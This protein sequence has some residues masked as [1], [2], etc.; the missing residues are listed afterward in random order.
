MN[1][2]TVK[3]IDL[4]GK[5]VIMRVDFN[6]PLDGT[7]ITDDTRVR[8]AM[9]TIQHLLDSGASLILM[10]H[11][12]RPSGTGY[13]AKFSLKP[14]ADH[15]GSLLG[16]PIQFAGDCIGADVQAQAAALQPGDVLLL[17]N[18]RFHLA[19][20][21]KAKTDGMGDEDAA[22]AKA[23]I[24]TAQQSMAQELAGLA[25]VYVNDAFGAAHRAH[26]STSVIADY[27]DTA[28]AGLLIEKE[29]NYLGK[30]L[31]GAESPFVAIIGGAKVSGK[32]E[33]LKTLVNKVDTLIIGGGMAYTFKKSRGETIGNS[34]CEDDLLDTARQI[35][36]DAAANGVKLLLPVDTVIA[37][38][39]SESANTQI[40][41]GNIPDDWEGLDVGPESVKLFAEAVAEAKTI[42]WNGPL[43]KFEWAPFAKGTM[44]ICQAVA[45]ADAV[46]IIGG[47]DSVSAVN[48][49]GLQDQMSHISTGG[50]ASLEFLEGKTLPGV[51]ALNDK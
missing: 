12:G 16:H 14:V 1:K 50:G 20:Q 42:I 9:P 31:N 8:A 25:D 32:L 7:T 40:V 47:G 45:D 51:A 2:K 28:V 49:S 19:E 48:S 30:A 38:D 5:R 34:I 3:D 35:E 41:Q 39:F 36:A 10:S 4:A 21:G 33:V 27:S 22:A 23:A 29:L 26:A 46:S 44:A 13:E 24:K 15:L 11:L 43:G 17:E 6:V 37:D 18:T